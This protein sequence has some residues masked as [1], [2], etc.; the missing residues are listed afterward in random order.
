MFK[1]KRDATPAGTTCAEYDVDHVPASIAFSVNTGT[2][3]IVTVATAVAP[4]TA[5]PVAAFVTVNCVDDADAIVTADRLNADVLRPV[6]VTVCPEANVFAAVYV[7]VPDAAEAAVTVAVIVVVDDA[8]L[9]NVMV[10]GSAPVPTI[11]RTYN[12]PPPF[13]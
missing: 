4:V 10:P 7:T 6:I 8:W 11:R 2:A 13:A 1:P 9:I 5:V 3:V 12:E